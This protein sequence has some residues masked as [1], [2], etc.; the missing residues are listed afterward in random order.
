MTTPTR[1]ERSLPS[2]LNELSAGPTPEYLDDVF[3]RTGRMRQRPAWTFPGRW[4]PMADITRTR[5]FAPTPPWRLIAV[6]L[7]VIAVSLVA[8]IIVA[9]SQRP[10]PTPFGPARNGLIPFVQGGDLYV[11]D[12][13]TGQARLVVGGPETDSVPGYSPD[14]TLLAFVRNG[15]AIFTVRPDGTDVRRITAEPLT[16]LRW[17]TWAPD[18]R[19]LLVIDS[20]ADSN[21]LTSIDVTGRDKPVRLAADYQPDSVVF[22]P[23]DAKEILFRDISDGKFGLYVMNADGTN[24]R[25]LLAPADLGD[26]HLGSVSYSVDGTRIIYQ[27]AFTEAE[28]AASPF[29]DNQCC[30]LWVMNADGTGAHEFTSSTTPSWDGL[31][32]TSPDGRWVALWHVTEQAHVGVMR[33]D[34]TGPITDISPA[35]DGNAGFGWAPDSTKVL[36]AP[37]DDVGGTIS[38]LL[39]PAGGPWTTIPWRVPADSVDWQRLAP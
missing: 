15:R 38:Y 7:V 29:P 28:A 31:V 21:V 33:A 5:A 24:V 22:R 39:D 2:I 3:G 19:H 34:G 10:L 32:N 17:A 27:R 13:V 9:G 30:K 11:G 36:M 16:N 4:F 6:A 37:A 8:L 18:S 14:G 23:P 12:P 35:L 25:Q 26:L 1:L 20:V